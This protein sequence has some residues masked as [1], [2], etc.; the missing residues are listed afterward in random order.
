MCMFLGLQ[1]N[2]TIVFE[3]EH[4]LELA[5]SNV[6]VQLLQ[7]SLQYYWYTWNQSVLSIIPWLL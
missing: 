1:K 3:D 5:C 4:R 7:S 2:E 6:H